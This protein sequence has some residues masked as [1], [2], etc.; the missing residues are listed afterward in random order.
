M[1][2]ETVITRVVGNPGNVIGFQ[3][4]RLATMNPGS[5]RNSKMA[6]TSKAKKKAGHKPTYHSGG[7]LAKKNPGK[8]HHGHRGGHRGN[9]GVFSGGVASTVTNALFVIVG[10]LGSKLGAQAALGTNNKDILGYF[11]NAVAGGIL[12]FGTSKLMK[13]KA[14]SDGVIAGTMVQII[15]R[16]LN[17]YTPFGSYVNQLGMGDYQAQS[18]VTPQVLLDPLGSAAL[19]IPDAWQSKVTTMVPAVPAAAAGMSGLY[20]TRGGGGAARRLYAA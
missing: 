13:N 3:L 8:P 9:P 12:W 18:F 19:R 10:A 20:N 11:A 1:A 14:A 7:K 16:V 2:K 5:R 6:Q 17:D 15:L 4:G